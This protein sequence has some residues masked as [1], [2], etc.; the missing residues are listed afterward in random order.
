MIFASL[1]WNDPRNSKCQPRAQ[2]P[3][4]HFTQCQFFSDPNQSKLYQ[5]PSL[6][7]VQSATCKG[8]TFKPCYQ[9]ICVTDQ[10]HPSNPC[11]I[12]ITL[13]IFLPF[14]VSKLTDAVMLSSQLSM[15]T[16]S[17]FSTILSSTSHSMRIM[18]SL[19]HN[20]P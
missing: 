6:N 11:P 19:H 5:L 1:K 10:N 3:F 9:L 17:H 7:L 15:T 14:L 16:Y 12:S 2:I 18:R 20:P 13:F 8:T 4:L